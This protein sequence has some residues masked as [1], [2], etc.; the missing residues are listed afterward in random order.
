MLL[1]TLFY[2]TIIAPLYTKK[3]THNNSNNKHKPV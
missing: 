2:S 3:L 1:V